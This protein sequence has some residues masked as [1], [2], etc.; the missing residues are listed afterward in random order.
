[1]N[2]SFMNDGSAEYV[3]YDYRNDIR[4]SSLLYVY[5]Y[6]IFVIVVLGPIGFY[7]IQKYKVT[8][9]GPWTYDTE[10]EASQYMV[11]SSNIKKQQ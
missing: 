11:D 2:D 3:S 6:S 7:R 5:S 10:G 1:M 9:G 8:I 4:L